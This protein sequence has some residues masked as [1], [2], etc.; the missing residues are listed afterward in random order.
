MTAMD[1]LEDAANDTLARPKLTYPCGDAPEAGGVREVAPGV[2]WV[3]MPLPFALQWINLWLIEDGEGFTLV[4]TCVATEP[5][6]EHWRQAADMNTTL[7]VKWTVLKKTSLPEQL[8]SPNMTFVR[9][10]L[11]AC[12]FFI[13]S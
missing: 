9:I 2:H 5:V 7:N 6:R 3:R 1:G 4:D 13:N 11:T 8:I 10:K 12:Q